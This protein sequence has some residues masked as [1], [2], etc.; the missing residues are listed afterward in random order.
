MPK[1]STGGSEKAV[2][3]F[4]SATQ[5]ILAENAR[6]E[7]ETLSPFDT[8]SRNTFFGSIFSNLAIFSSSNNSFIKTMSSLSSIMSSSIASTLPTASAVAETRVVNQRGD[9]PVLKSI[10]VTGDAYCNPYQTS[11]LS[12]ID[13]DA[14]D[15]YYEALHAKPISENGTPKTFSPTKTSGASCSVYKASTNFKL[16][17]PMTDLDGDCWIDAAVDENHNPIIN[18][19]S[20]LGAFASVCGQRSSVTWGYADA[21]VSSVVASIDFEKGE[22]SG[23]G[24]LASNGI[25]NAIPIVGDIAAAQDAINNINNVNWINGQICVNSPQNENWPRMK[26][27][28]HY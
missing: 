1:I 13:D 15:V 4:R 23:V 18:P 11:D 19:Y 26:R 12:T 17:D 25:V 3:A 27:Y 9:C 5:E 8:S 20:E 7:R 24:E 14:L 16:S 28:Q 21:G 10:D 22:K 2:F 6:Y